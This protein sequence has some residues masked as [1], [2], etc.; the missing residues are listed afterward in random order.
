MVLV[1]LGMGG[2]KAEAQSSVKGIVIEMAGGKRTEYALTETPKLTY[3][4]NTVTLTTTKGS[5]EFTATDIVKVVLTD[6]RA[7]SID[8]VETEQRSFQ[9]SND[10]VRMSGLAAD[11]IVKLYNVGGKLLST[12]RTASSGELIIKLSDLKQGIYIIKANQQ[13]LKVTRK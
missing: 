6:I 9:L 7:T 4:D 1:L 3:N 5:V 11:E 10:E 12:W 2:I 8:A 13:S